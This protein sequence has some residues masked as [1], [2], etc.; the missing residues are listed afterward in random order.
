MLVKKFNKFPNFL[1]ST[2]K[3]I[4]DQLP[5]KI[6]RNGI[7]LFRWAKRF[8]SFS[9]LPFEKAYRQSYSYY[10]SA[11]LKKLLTPSYWQ[12]I[13]QVETE[14]EAAFESNF[15]DDPVNQICQTD[16]HMFMVGLN[17]TYTDRA[18]MAASVEVR[19]PFIDRKVIELAMQIPGKLKYYRSNLK[20]ILKAAAREFLPTYIIN[21]KK[22]SFGAPIRSWISNDLKPLVDDLLSKESVNHRGILNYDYVLELIEDD[23]AGKKDNAYQIY[24]L[25]TLELWFRIFLD[26]HSK[27]TDIEEH[28]WIPQIQLSKNYQ[29]I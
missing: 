18:S 24:Q 20:A 26:D 23:R 1:K 11:E 2:I 21:R 8:L 4:A 7:R 6:G 22:A 3:L 28:F 29:A 9:N 19:V 16:L 15:A 17:L 13:H 5:V 10:N 12:A 27:R 25:L 14:H